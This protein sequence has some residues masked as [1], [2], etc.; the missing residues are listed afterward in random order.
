VR[1]A[2]GL[3]LLLVGLGGMLTTGG[4]PR[5]AA[6]ATLRLFG[7]ISR[8]A[9]GWQ[10]VRMR[11]A[12]QDG[13]PDLAYARAEVALELDPSATEGW[14]YLAANMAF[15]RASPYRQPRPELRTR[16]TEAA[17]EVLERGEASATRPAELAVQGGLILVLVGESEGAIP[18]PG[19]AAAAWQEADGAFERA[20]RHDPGSAE[21]WNQRAA[22][23][24][25]R[26]GGPELVPDAAG[27]RAALEA[28]LKLLQQARPGVR[29]Q[30]L[31]DFQRG[32][33]LA[34]FAESG[35]GATWPGGQAALLLQA[36][37]AFEAAAEAG[38]PL[39]P[40]AVDETRA[41]LDGLS[42]R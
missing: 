31:I 7:P 39:A 5:P 24:V 41:A 18:W 37:A 25:L 3:A 10:W 2:V 22:N 1:R 8:L 42:D 27:R 11:M 28:G 17:L 35:D 15:D 40:P 14:A 23:R 30:D 38:F 29:R 33:L 34:V 13:Q 9:A 36:L 19:G 4:G 12:L 20:T 32:A 6:S 26:L 21:G 16:W